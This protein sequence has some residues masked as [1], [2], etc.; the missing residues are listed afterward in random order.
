MSYHWSYC[1]TTGENYKNKI[2]YKYV[3]I[4][5]LVKKK[6]CPEPRAAL[7]APAT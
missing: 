4:H 5:T 2:I 6:T 7:G 1:K 3:D